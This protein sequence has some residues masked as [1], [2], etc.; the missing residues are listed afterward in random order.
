LVV[1]ASH[2]DSPARAI[3]RTLSVI[4]EIVGRSN[5]IALLIE[6]P[7][8]L[9]TLIRLC[10][11][12][13]WIAGRLADQPALLDAFLD[14]SQLYHPPARDELTDEL[15][16]ELSAFVLEDLEH[17]M[18]AL[19]HFTQRTMLRIAAADVTDAMPL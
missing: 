7:A 9:A 11:A 15:E 18:D 1:M 3:V 12:S 6:Y 19:R 13:Q 14:Q 17:R 2:H 16:E 5:Y 4:S 10:A 8:A